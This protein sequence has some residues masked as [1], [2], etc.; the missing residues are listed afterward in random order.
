LLRTTA[1]AKLADTL[2]SADQAASA[3][4]AAAGDADAKASA[5]AGRVPNA[6]IYDGWFK[7]ADADCDGRLT[8][9]DAVT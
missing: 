4:A 2:Y 5:A 8:G 3:A 9:A 1:V 7:W 6:V